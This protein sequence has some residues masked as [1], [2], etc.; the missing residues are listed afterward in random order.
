MQQ[1]S[2]AERMGDGMGT[3]HWSLQ[4]KL[5]LSR[6]DERW[7]SIHVANTIVRFWVICALF[8][9]GLWVLGF[10]YL[11]SGHLAHILL[12]ILHCIDFDCRILMHQDVPSVISLSLY[13]AYN[14]HAVCPSHSTIRIYLIQDL[15]IQCPLLDISNLS[16]Q[17]I[18]TLLNMFVAGSRAFYFCNICL[19][20]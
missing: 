1:R 8:L 15:F 3:I 9:L 5:S 20:S 19:C 11:S 2:T 18:Y 10:S 17:Q 6:K 16:P 13:Q 4:A 12:F 14:I 7:F